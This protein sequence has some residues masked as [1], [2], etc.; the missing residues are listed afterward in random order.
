LR[1]HSGHPD[2]LPDGRYEG[3]IDALAVKYGSGASATRT[4]P[5][6]APNIQLRRLL[7]APMATLTTKA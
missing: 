2:D 4:G 1:N 6:T 7:R 3:A 5:W